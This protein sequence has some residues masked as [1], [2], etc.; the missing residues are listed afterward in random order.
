MALIDPDGLFDGDRIAMLSDEAKLYWPYFWCASSPALARLELSYSKIWARAFHNFRKPPSEQAFWSMVN[1]YADRFLLF[2]YK[3]MS[4]RI[5][6]Q[7]DAPSITLARYKS[8]ADKRMPAPPPELFR[9]W[10]RRYADKKASRVESAVCG[11]SEKFPHVVGVGVGVG[12][13]DGEGIKPSSP[14]NGSGSLF[15]FSEAESKPDCSGSVTTD[16]DRSGSEPQQALGKVSSIQREPTQEEKLAAQY[17]P[18]IHARHVARKCSLKAARELL[19]RIL[20]RRPRPEQVALAERID[21][22][23]QAYCNSYDWTKDGGQ[24]CPSLEKWL[25]VNQERYLVEL[26]EHLSV[27]ASNGHKKPEFIQ[28]LE[29]RR[30]EAMAAAEGSG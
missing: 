15:D 16:P 26:V 8:A 24:F 1:E 13:V 17:A 29:R 11:I 21:K 2:V 12:V 5:W 3:D 25:N 23:H 22:N 6:G 30:K 10:K 19:V 28:E 4:G 18:A 14:K 27:E 20:K 9:E 7:W